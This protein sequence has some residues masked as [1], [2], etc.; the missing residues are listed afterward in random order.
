MAFPT[1]PASRLARRVLRVTGTVQGVGFRPFVF[2]LAESLDLGGYVL[3]DSA[4]VLI[5][6]EGEPDHIAE[7]ARRLLDEAPPLARIATVTSVDALPSR[8]TSGFRIV[9]SH[10]DGT[11]DAPVSIDSATCPACLAEVDDPTDRRHRYPFTNCTNCGPR[12]TIVLGVPYDR[13]ATTMAAF[14][15]CDACRAE[16]D[17]P[18]DR[19]FHAQPNACPMCG[20]HLTWRD[21]DGRA[22]ADG[23]EALDAAIEALTSGRIVAVK[24]IGGYHLAVD[25]TD[26][27][28]VAELRRRKARDDKPFAVMVQDLAAARLVCTLDAGAAAALSSPRRPIV[29]APRQLQSAVVNAVAPGLPEIGVL[30]PYSPLH[31]LLL[32]GTGRPLVMTSGNHSDE[33]I[34]HADDDAVTRLGPLADAL[35]THDRDIHIR[36]DDS[37]AR[38][39]AGRLQILRR[40]RGYAPEPLPLPFPATRQVLAVG[41]E[42][43]STISVAKGTIVVP[44]HHIGD[45]EHLATH[46]SFIQALDHI[47]ALYGVTPAVVAHDLHPEYLSTKLAVALGLPTVGVQHHHA[48]VAACMVEHGRIAPVLGLAFDGLGYGP[49]GSLWGGELLVA[50]LDSFE[51]VGHLAGVPM[52]GGTAAI[53]EPWRMAAVWVARAIDRAA[54]PGALPGLDAATREAVLDLAERPLSPITTSMGRLFDAAAALLGGRRRVSYEAQAA[55]EL[56]ALAR[57]VDRADAPTY[58]GTV[59]V[60]D[61]DGM[62]VIDPA[63]LVRRVVHDVERGVPAALIAAGFHEAIGRATAEVG[64]TLASQRGLGCVALTGGVFQNLRLTEVVEAALTDAGFE[65]LVH[66]AVPPNDGGISIGQAAVAAHTPPPGDAA[67]RR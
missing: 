44:S 6:V 14:T 8:S 21:R 27:R 61:V 11:P 65:V 1:D 63:G 53:R 37:V 64:A 38:A 12:Y 5:D 24:G 66:Q 13:P 60:V 47:C 4:G 25:A 56:E 46:R 32:A 34:A 57:T 10:D 3:N 45:L 9:E 49:D 28:A 51:R 42:L 20:P 15:M 67:D 50:D 41:A 40:S 39:G 36:C 62:T 58:T 7:L 35:L 16:Y 30:L 29:L 55:I 52:P 33:P 43:K 19:R 23:N 18:R 54:V 31:H 59:D 22:L 17:D 2:R 48:H 26:E